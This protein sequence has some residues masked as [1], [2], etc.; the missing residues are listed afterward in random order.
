MFFVTGVFLI[1]DPYDILNTSNN[2]ESNEIYMC[3]ADDKKCQ[4]KKYSTTD[5]IGQKVLDVTGEERR[6]QFDVWNRSKFKQEFFKLFPHFTDMKD[7]IENH[8]RGKILTTYLLE[9]IDDIEA[10]FVSGKITTEEAKRKFRLLKY[11]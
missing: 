4:D 9:N 3:H 10:N 5:S 2:E 11:K 1:I 7:F 8:L 6:V